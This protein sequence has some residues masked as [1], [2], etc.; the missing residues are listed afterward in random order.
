[1]Q[2]RHVFCKVAELADAD[3]QKRYKVHLPM[4]V[5]KRDPVGIRSF[6]FFALNIGCQIEAL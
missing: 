6:A 4:N 5:P 1:M 3:S 2:R